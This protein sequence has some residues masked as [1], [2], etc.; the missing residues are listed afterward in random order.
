VRLLVQDVDIARRRLSLAMENVDVTHQMGATVQ[1]TELGTAA[2]GEKRT[3]E[4][5]GSASSSGPKRM[6]Q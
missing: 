5:L 1:A 3:V 6:K 4:R 2:S